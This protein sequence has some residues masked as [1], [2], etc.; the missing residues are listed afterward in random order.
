MPRDIWSGTLSFGLVVIPV[1]MVSAT[2]DR[3][4]HFHQVDARTGERAV[5]QRVAD[6]DG[7]E[8][9]WEEIGHGYDLDGQLVTLT[10]DELATV[11][12]EHTHT[13]EIQEFVGL[14]EISPVQLDKH[15]WL[16]P[17][18]DSEGALRAYALLRDALTKSEL[19][20]VG[21]VVIRA[22]EQLVTVSVRDDLLALTTLLFAAE[23][24]DPE[25][26][27]TL[28]DADDKP[29][30]AELTEAKKL[31][32]KLT[33]EFD[34]SQY[35]D[36]HRERLLEQ[37]ERKQASSKGGKQPAPVEAAPS[38]SKDLL[39]ALKDSLAREK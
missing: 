10:D 38:P 39:A 32:D 5:V 17:N 28:P 2:R 26:I 16:L 8:V 22:R 20:A 29:K 36:R 9:P 34:P 15:Y 37:V 12:P 14:D 18:S 30:R 13:I 21:T 11:A 33:T 7:R 24:R 27:G 23:V 3:G 4:V 1:R 25:A 19:M 31:I 6:V 35:E